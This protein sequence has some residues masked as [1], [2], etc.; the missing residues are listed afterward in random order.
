MMVLAALCFSVAAPFTKLAIRASS[1]YVAFGTAQMVGVVIIIAWLLIRGRLPAVLGEA[2][3]HAGR[4]LIVGVA[5]LL[6]AVTTYLAFDLMLV[7]YASGIKGSNIL[8]TALLG[9]FF[10][11]EDR[12]GRTLVVG[13][14]MVAG[15]VLLSLG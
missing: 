12:I 8:I 4:L 13:T 15:V 5:N 1:I 14:I 6:Q 7:A 3:R 11:A 2:R 10:F 9:H